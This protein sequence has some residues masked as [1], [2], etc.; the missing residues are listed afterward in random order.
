MEV[1]FNLRYSTEIGCEAIKNQVQAILNKYG[2]EYEINWHLSGEPYLTTET[3]LIDIVVASVAEETG[4]TP[5][6]PPLAE[7]QTVVLSL[8]RRS[9]S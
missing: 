4:V 6:V 9:S 3:E 2:I 5:N 8:L 7:L 1:G